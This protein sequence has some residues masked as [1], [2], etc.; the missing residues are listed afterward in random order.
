MCNDKE[1]AGYGLRQDDPDRS[2]SH[3]ELNPLTS[4]ASGWERTGTESVTG[5]THSLSAPSLST[6]QISAYSTAGK[7]QSKVLLFQSRPLRRGLTVSMFHPLQKGQ[8]LL[9][10]LT[11][12]YL[13]GRAKPY[14]KIATL[15][16]SA[17]FLW[18]SIL[19]LQWPCC[20]TTLNLRGK[21]LKTMETLKALLSKLL[22]L[23]NLSTNIL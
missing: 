20:I 21:V 7:S 13:Q 3:P 4:P 19:V 11:E 16:L 22:L 17:L 23:Y 8:G 15:L 2:T 1:K 5:I 10:L 6:R 18:F 14:V 12:G 9:A